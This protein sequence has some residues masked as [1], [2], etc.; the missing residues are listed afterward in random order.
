MLTLKH[1]WSDSENYVSGQQVTL[2]AE[3]VTPLELPAD[4][5]VAAQIVTPDEQSKRSI[6]LAPVGLLR[7]H[8]HCVSFECDADGIGFSADYVRGAVTFHAPPGRFNRVFDRFPVGG[9]GKGELVL[10]DGHAV[11]LPDVREV[12]VELVPIT[13][14]LTVRAFSRGT[15]VAHQTTSAAPM[16]MEVGSLSVPDNSIDRIEV[17][18]DPAAALMLKLC[19][20]RQASRV[21]RSSYYV[22]SFTLDPRAAIGCY[23]AYLYVQTV[24]DVAPGT[25]A[26]V[27][28]QT[29]GGLAAG[30]NLTTQPSASG[31]CAFCMVID[32]T[33]HVVEPPPVVLK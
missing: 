11:T 21:N 26:A 5:H 7:P 12:M 30:Q 32:H 14:P 13:G 24:N 20:S 4:F 8:S 2:F 15:E 19:Y 16:T 6:V 33:F 25:D 28:A 9:D 10:Y 3:V 29:I 27:A 31:G 1:L 22:G 17:H 23:K 18:G